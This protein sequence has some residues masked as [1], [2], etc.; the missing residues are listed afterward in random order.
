MVDFA[1]PLTQ[2][3]MLVAAALRSSA[4]AD[5]CEV[6]DMIEAFGPLEPADYDLSA[7]QY[8]DLFGGQS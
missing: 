6:L 8:E 1:R 3:D 7:R 5:L 4:L 2:D